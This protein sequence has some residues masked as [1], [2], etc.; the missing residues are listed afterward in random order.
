MGMRAFRRPGPLAAVAI[1][2]WFGVA[3]CNGANSPIQ[4]PL[5]GASALAVQEV[6]SGLLSPVY[7]TAPRGDSRLFVVEQAGIIRIIENGQL[8]SPA[9]LDIRSIVQAGGEQ[10]LLSMAFHPDYG[11][12]GLFYVYY[13]D[14]NGDSRVARYAVSGD[15]DVADPSSGVGLLTVGQP[16]ANHN[17]GLLLFGPD[18]MLY[19]GLGDG[20]SGG[21]PQGHGQNTN[22]LLGSLLRIDVDAGNP[23]AIPGDNPFGN[24]IWAYGLRNP[25]RFAFDES[26]E[27]LY[28][29]DVGQNRLE[30]VN[31]M[32]GTTPGVNYGWNVMEG[33]DCFAPSSGCSTSGLQLPAL[34][35]DHGQGCSVTGGFVYRGSAI[36]GIRGHYF[37]SDY[38]SGWL[39]SFRFDGGSVVDGT[40]WE[41]GDLG[42][43][44]SFGEGGDGEL[45]ILSSNGRVF[46]LVTAG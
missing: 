6:V 26:T 23:Y 25:W 8:R 42:S 17:G 3:G 27:L 7:L 33:N 30:E 2:L 22:T 11:V 1:G 14:D 34:E 13:T 32:P 31:V 24:E 45:Y 44:T 41:V 46:R 38:C 35:Y 21:D 12:N 37:Y 5:P 40:Q 4:P 19:V 43:V 36:T 29:A 9:F 10:G 39:R 15:P 20:G 18:G 16:F 28:L